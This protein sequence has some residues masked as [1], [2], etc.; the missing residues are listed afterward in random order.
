LTAQLLLL[1]WRALTCQF[2]CGAA[3]ERSSFHV[4]VTRESHS[5]QG[6]YPGI[7]NRKR[8]GK[9]QSTDVTLAAATAG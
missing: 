6:R 7:W 8:G 5:E 9:Q 1:Y 3:K 4:G 2:G